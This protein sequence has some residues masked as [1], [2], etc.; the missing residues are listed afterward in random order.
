M[1]YS[2]TDWKDRVVTS[3]LTYT[4]SAP[5]TANTPFTLIPAE[6]GV[7]EPGTPLNSVNLNKLETQYENAINE[8][9]SKAG[10]HLDGPLT[11]D[12][13]ITT[14]AN[15]NGANG[16]FTGPVTA[17]GGTLTGDLTLRNAN[18]KLSDG[19]TVVTALT[20]KA[21]DSTGHG[22]ALGSGGVCVVGSGESASAFL[23]TQNGNT[24]TTYV[25]SDN[26]VFLITGYQTPA[27]KKQ[28]QFGNDGKFTPPTPTWINLTLLNGALVNNNRTPQY[29]I[30]NGVV[31]LRGE[32]QYMLGVI[33][34]LPVGY[35]ADSTYA[36]NLSTPVATT[37]VVG[38]ALVSINTN[39]DI[40]ILRSGNTTSGISLA[41]ISFVAG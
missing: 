12:S 18:L 32:V 22:I 31:R 40:Q 27:N 9:L 34:N 6:G 39:G 38:D 23:A 8:S 37:A 26:D 21:G 5:I 2:K 33:G 7:T 28:F 14:T 1:P 17:V 11:S 25:T 16:N 4:V 35:R 3:P 29:C 10:G 24:E 13:D 20:F 36:L 15:L 41:G 19:T 30:H